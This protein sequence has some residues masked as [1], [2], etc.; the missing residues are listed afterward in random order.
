[1][2]PAGGAEAELAAR[3]RDLLQRSLTCD[4]QFVNVVGAPSIDSG[5]DP[6]HARD[7]SDIGTEAHLQVWGDGPGLVNRPPACG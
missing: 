7:A 3:I 6:G 1:M 4:G 5:S 2:T